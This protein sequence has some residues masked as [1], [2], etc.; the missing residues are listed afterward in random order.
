METI[1]DLVRD[2]LPLMHGESSKGWNSVYCAVC[3][4]GTHS[5]GP[6]GG[7]LFQDEMC[8]YNCFNCSTDG[9]FDPDREA[10]HS[11]NMWDIFRAFGIPVKEV[12][13][14]LASKIKDD[15]KRVTKA[16][17]IILPSIK[18][19]DFFKPITAYAEDDPLACEARDFLWNKYKM[20]Q[21][22]YPFFLSKGKTSSVNP[23]DIFLA[24][25]LLPRIIIPTYKNNGDLMYWQAR[26][27]FG[28]S[29]KKYL[30]ASVENSGAVIYGTENINNEKY[31]DRPLYITEGFFDSWHVNGVAIITNNMKTSKIKLLERNKR[32]KVVIPDY[33]RDGMNLADQAINEGWGIS[34]PAYLPHRDICSAINH[35]G[36][37]YVLK[38]IIKNTYYSFEAKM[39]LKEF[40]L[41]NYKFLD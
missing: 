8:F 24:K 27:F 13:G 3:G 4:D 22:D 40:K 33:N 28:E 37:L 39:R 35:F 34:L 1:E 14:L 15:K 7:W 12:N 38:T 11:K 16:E 17:K 31:K 25:N 20:T 2:H 6:R 41:K 5:K 10:P 32:D 18:Q 21:D 29:N 36:K 30:S 26:I 19:P 23:D 9:S